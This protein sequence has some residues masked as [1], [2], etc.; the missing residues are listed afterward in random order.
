[1]S[2]KHGRCNSKEFYDLDTTYETDRSLEIEEADDVYEMALEVLEA[3]EAFRLQSSGSVSP[4]SDVDRLLENAD[5]EMYSGDVTLVRIFSIRQESESDTKGSVRLKEKRVPSTSSHDASCD[6]ILGRNVM[7]ES[8]EESGTRN[9]LGGPGAEQP[10]GGGGGVV[11][12]TVR[13]SSSEPCVNRAPHVVCSS[14]DF[15]S[16]D[17]Q[18]SA[19]SSKVFADR[20]FKTPSP[21]PVTDFS[22]STELLCVARFSNVQSKDAKIRTALTSRSPPPHRSD[23]EAEDSDMSLHVTSLYSAPDR[24]LDDSAAVDRTYCG[25]L[26]VNSSGDDECFYGRFPAFG[27]REP[28][29]EELF[30]EALETRSDLASSID[31]SV[32]PHGSYFDAVVGGVRRD[33][34][35]DDDDFDLA[36]ETTLHRNQSTPDP[37]LSGFTDTD[38]IQSD[39]SKAVEYDSSSIGADI[40]RHGHCVSPLESLGS[41]RDVVPDE[42]TTTSGRPTAVANADQCSVSLTVDDEEDAKTADRSRAYLDPWSSDCPSSPE[43]SFLA[44]CS[45]DDCIG[46]S[47][48]DESF[49]DYETPTGT[50][51]TASKTDFFHRLLS[52]KE[53]FDAVGLWKEFPPCVDGDGEDPDNVRI[54]SIEDLLTD[55]ENERYF[56]EVEAPSLDG[57]SSAFPRARDKGPPGFDGV[58]PRRVLPDGDGHEDAPTVALSPPLALAVR[59][60]I[61]FAKKSK[62]PK[63]PESRSDLSPVRISW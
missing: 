10:P 40:R 11:G 15:A 57:R 8:E 45:T 13:A 36:L 32:H 48:G 22:D 35:P 2:G 26:N 6:S 60:D 38:N 50:D 31:S 62:I 37:L 5:T 53:R 4:E 21:P 39:L 52:R 51:S 19:E 43:P 42:N 25:T 46:E 18:H 24:C 1:M 55:S 23:N 61:Q 14:P 16:L 17:S 7:V 28:S 58:G 56:G 63:L 9:S 27:F 33:P 44:E 20:D 29:P 54:C 59:T 3:D 41:S 12:A 30:D 49:T 47:E 34:T